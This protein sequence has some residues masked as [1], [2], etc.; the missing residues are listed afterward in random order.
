M[1]STEVRSTP[2]AAL[3]EA[4]VSVDA[5]VCKRVPKRVMQRLEVDDRVPATG[6]GVLLYPHIKRMLD[7]A[8]AVVALAFL[9]PLLVMAWFWFSVKNGGRIL[10][11]KARAGLHC[12]PFD[13]YSFATDQRLLRRLPVLF[14]ILKG[15]MSFIG[16]RA[17]CPGE[18]CVEC[19]SMPVAHKRS[20]VRPGLICDWWIRRHI[21]L[22]Y[23]REIVLDV[24]YVESTSFRKDA[25]IVL[26]A[27]PGMITTL[28]WGDEPVEYPP[29]VEI[30]NVRIDNLTMQ[31]A[32]AGVVGLLDGR[33]PRQV[34]FVNPHY[35]NEAFRVPA[36]KRVLDEAE[37]VFAD[38]FGTRIAGKILRRPIRQNLCGTDLF[39]RLCAALDEGARS[40]YLLGAAPGAAELV[41]DWIR[42]RY[43]GV[44]IKGC[45]HGFFS[46]A[47]EMAVVEEIA[48]SGAD[49]LIA[50]MGVPRQELWL[51]RH[52]EQLNVKVAIGFG[53]LFDYFAGRVP[54]A[55][56]WVREIGMEWVYRLIQEPR[57]MW[58]RYLIG[59]GLFLGRVLHQRLFPREWTVRPVENRIGE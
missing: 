14:N 34:C 2:L 44:V 27:L 33:K 35:I 12:R 41:A 4:T 32:V 43:P 18:M 48:R 28:F 55:P 54:R 52:L 5:F 23:V 11:R 45:H 6:N 38:G 13:E 39:P 29:R 31:G 30:L 1:S 9:S 17:A 37:L 46:V 8:L 42:E 25:G 36:Y 57:R 24:A 19:R 51:H 50:A 59:N 53:G 7:I 56:Q 20:A 21:S 58:R 22:D 3:G 15:D 26:R 49:I 40:I 47:E 16:P 10:D